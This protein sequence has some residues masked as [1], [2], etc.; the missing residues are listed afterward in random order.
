MSPTRLRLSIVHVN[1][2]IQ[3]LRNM[4]VL[5]KTNR[6]I[7]VADGKELARIA[8]FDGSYLNMTRLTSKWVVQINEPRD[9]QNEGGGDASCRAL[10][11]LRSA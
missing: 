10:T 8:E 6:A 4:D 7:E 9:R 3:T 11:R 1:R 5:S 2:L